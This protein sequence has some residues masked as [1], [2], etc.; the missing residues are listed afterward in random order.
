MA[1]DGMRGVLWIRTGVR[2]NL[3][4]DSMPAGAFLPNMGTWVEHDIWPGDE[5]LMLIDLVADAESLPLLVVG[6]RL[7]LHD[8]PSLVAAQGVVIGVELDVSLP[9]PDGAY[10]G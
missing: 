3:R 1:Y 7:I 8:G 9:L 5:G 4:L 2:H 10:Q 6:A